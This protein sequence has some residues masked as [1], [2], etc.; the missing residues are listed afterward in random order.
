MTDI[1][2]LDKI[3]N[4]ERD[5]IPNSILSRVKVIVQNRKD[6]S[7][8]KIMNSSQAAGGLARWCQAI[9]RYAE[10]LKVVRPKQQRVEEMNKIYQEKM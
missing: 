2:F 1:K 7:V 6:F 10:A 9:F 5:H 4:Y 8:E 3:K